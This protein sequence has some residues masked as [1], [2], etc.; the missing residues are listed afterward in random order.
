[1]YCLLVNP[2]NEKADKAAKSALSKPVLLIP[3][4]Y[5]DLKPIVNKYIH[6]KWQQATNTK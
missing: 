4:P 6:D 3:I 2:G 1:V 5:T